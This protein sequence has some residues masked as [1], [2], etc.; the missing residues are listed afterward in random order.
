MSALQLLA[1]AACVVVFVMLAAR[2]ALGIGA[3]LAIYPLL[4]QVPRSPVPGLNPETIL[5]LFAMILTLARS[6]MHVPP[7]RISGPVLAFVA[8]MFLAWVIGRTVV[9]QFD[10]LT[11]AWERFK[12]LKSRTFA[13][14][15]FFIAYWWIRNPV[16]RRRVIEGISVAMLVVGLAGLVAVGGSAERAAGLFQNANT[17]GDLLGVFLL[18][19]LYLVWLE[20]L[21]K[22]RRALHA[23][24]YLVGFMALLYTLSRGGWL[25]Y[26]VGHVLFFLL[27][28]RRI[29]V[30]GTAAAALMLTVGLPLAPEAVRDRIGGTF[31]SSS[32]TVYQVG[33][34][35]DIEGSA[36]SRVVVYKMGFDMFLDS[37][38]WGHGAGAFKAN[39]RTYGAR[40]GLLKPKTPH[41]FPLELLSEAGLL[42]LLALGWLSASVLLLGF[43][44]LGRE[45]ESGRLGVLLLAL[46][47]S[48]GFANLFHSDFLTNPVS[49]RF[50][51]AIFGLCGAAY[52]A[53]SEIDPV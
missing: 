52:F 49:A 18:C 6:G 15:L 4:T 35:L 11:A 46:G 2:P 24:S 40:Y 37:P 26:G 41:S 10:P 20:D 27:I 12:A 17:T 21:P 51:W 34:T 13:V 48:T 30:L 1:A 3:L 7:L 47:I 33:G 28:D 29:L 14:L 53:P 8:V 22:A 16:E 42:G 5:L 23:A 25:A 44:L 31:E 39:S 43:S 19:P 36:A 45:G 38:L 9:D 32:Q 50:F